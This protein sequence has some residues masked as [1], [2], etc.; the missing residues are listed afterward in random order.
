MSGSLWNTSF[1]TYGAYRINDCSLS[2][3]EAKGERELPPSLPASIAADDHVT[4]A[5]GVAD[6]VR[7]DGGGHGELDGGG[8]HDAHDVA[9][10]R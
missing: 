10:A 6:G 5:H 9:R 3:S 7:D 4:R 1:T 2:M 8:V